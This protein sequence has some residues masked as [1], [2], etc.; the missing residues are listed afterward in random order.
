VI[1]DESGRIWPFVE[2]QPALGE[3]L[4]PRGIAAEFTKWP[5]NVAEYR[6]SAFGP[7]LSGRNLRIVLAEFDDFMRCAGESCRYFFRLGS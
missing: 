2:G 1:T 3:I 7:G 5:P 4:L 6:A